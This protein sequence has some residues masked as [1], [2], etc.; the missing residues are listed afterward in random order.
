MLLLE[1]ILKIKKLMSLNE[2][3]LPKNNLFYGFDYSEFKDV[4]PPSDDSEKTKK[5]L[6]YLRSINLD[7]LFIQEKD[8]MLGNFLGFLDEKKIKYDRKFLKKLYDD[9]YHIVLDLKSYYKRPR[10][11]RL[12][13]SLTDTILDSMEGF[14]Y[15][16]GHS[17]TSNLL[18]LVLIELYPEHKKDFNKICKDI[19]NSRQMAKAH[20]PSDIKFGEKLAKSMFDY[21]KTNDLIH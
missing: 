1:E 19:T 18:C 3:E 17:T 13:P 11:F 6:D 5:E 20:Y 4:P 14:A 9:L 10:P 21:L 15:P 12:D 2:S 7:K 8:D 16:S